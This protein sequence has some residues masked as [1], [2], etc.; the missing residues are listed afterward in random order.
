MRGCI[1]HGMIVC[2]ALKLDWEF[3]H[4]TAYMY[5]IITL[6]YGSYL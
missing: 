2:M 4:R 6:L 1:E 3:T 5:M